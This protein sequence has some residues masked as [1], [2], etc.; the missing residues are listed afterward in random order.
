MNM[1]YLATHSLK[2]NPFSPDVPIEAVHATPA[3]ENFCW[4]IEH[5]QLR[6]GGF[7]LIT[8]SPGA[9]KSVAL[10]LLAE[11]LSGIPDVTV[12]AMAHPQSA[13]NDFYR[14]LG[15]LFQVPLTPHNRWCGFKALRERWMNHLESTRCKPVLL[16][17]EAQEMNASVL[18]ELR[19]LA[20]AK[21]DSRS[22]LCVVLA[23]DER[24]IEML[25]RDDLLPL[26]SRIR[27]RL[28][29]DS[30]T[31]DELLATLE[32]QLTAAGNPDLMTPA[33]KNTLCEHAIGNRRM[34][35]NFAHDLL[36]TAVRDKRPQLDEKLYFDLFGKPVKRAPRGVSR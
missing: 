31:P 22:L 23:G 15:D 3:V 20:S 6:E 24:L 35:N 26:A 19:L 1:S 2:W 34:L 28:S 18:S 9:G 27:V 5:T 7:S 32:H 8:G 33:L 14:E 25:R 4:R 11:R 13:I 21:F 30:A 29:L 16:I 10:R 17:D 12:G 36:A